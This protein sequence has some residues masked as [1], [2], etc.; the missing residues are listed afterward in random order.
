MGGG[1]Q[2]GEGQEEGEGGQQ[3]RTPTRAQTRTPVSPE[4]EVALRSVSLFA[5]DAFNALSVAW[6]ALSVYSKGSAPVRPRQQSCNSKQH[7][8]N[9][10]TPRNEFSII[11]RCHTGAIHPQDVPARR[12]G[13]HRRTQPEVSTV[14]GRSRRKRSK[15]NQRRGRRT[16]PLGGWEERRGVPANADTSIARSGWRGGHRCWRVRLHRHGPLVWRRAD[17]ARLAVLGRVLSGTLRRRGQAGRGLNRRPN[18]FRE[19]RCERAAI[20]NGWFENT[21]IVA[22]KGYS[23][24]HPTC[25]EFRAG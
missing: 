9:K 4:I 5:S 15:R 11:V 8:N 10:T 23:H 20:S 6:C 12:L 25:R 13:H 17:G 21:I 24:W 14:D 19:S 18:V 7:L 2:V 1:A 22:T 16:L 3:G